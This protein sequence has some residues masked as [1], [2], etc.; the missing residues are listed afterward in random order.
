MGLVRG[1]K[2]EKKM[3]VGKKKSHCDA[4][5]PGHRTSLEG[6]K[7]RGANKATSLLRA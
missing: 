2:R 1:S 4:R 6:S 3:G 7:E 5:V